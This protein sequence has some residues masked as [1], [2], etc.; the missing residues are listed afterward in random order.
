MGK[1]PFISGIVL[2]KQKIKVLIV[3]VLVFFLSFV[4]NSKTF[5]PSI[6]GHTNRHTS[7]YLLVVS[8]FMSTGF[9]LLLMSQKHIKRI[10][11]DDDKKTVTILFQRSFAKEK[12]VIIDYKRLVY[13]TKDFKGNYRLMIVED[14]N[15]NFI[16]SEFDDVRTQEI[17]RAI[18]NAGGR[19]FQ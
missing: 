16:I 13:K 3:F 14:K 18:E 6:N 8:S 19:K 17:E 4:L 15:W 2:R 11:F 9:A 10:D 12:K 5:R 1:Q 7:T